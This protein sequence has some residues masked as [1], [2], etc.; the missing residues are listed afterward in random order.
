M[1]TNMR[2]VNH[3]Q[4]DP[5]HPSAAASSKTFAELD[6]RG[7]AKWLSHDPKAPVY[8]REGVSSKSDHKCTVADVTRDRRAGLDGADAATSAGSL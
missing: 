4:N 7:V 1:A 3:Q 2:A 5:D 8:A 6:A